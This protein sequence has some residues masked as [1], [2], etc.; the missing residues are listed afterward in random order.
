MKIKKKFTLEIIILSV[1]LAITSLIIIDNT[2]NVEENFSILNDELIP[3]LSLLKDMR[4]MA[5]N[6]LISTLEFT[7]F[8]EN[9]RVS[10]DK[11]HDTNLQSSKILSEIEEN[12][13]LFIQLFELYKHQVSG[14]IATESI[15]QINL[16]WEEFTIISDKF[17]DYRKRGISGDEF[18]KIKNEFKNSKDV[19]F[20]EIDSLLILNEKQVEQKGKDVSELVKFSTVL[21]IIV[22][23]VFIFVLIIL[24]HYLLKSILKPIFQIR[25]ATQEIAKNKLHLR[26]DDISKD[27]IG[28]LS[29]DINLMTHKLETVQDKLLKSE[30]LSVVGVLAGRMAHDIRN[31]LAIIMASLEILKLK[32][33]D[34]ED[35]KFTKINNAVNRI[36]HQ[37]EDVLD[38]V[39]TTP[40]LIEKTSIL[41]ILTNILDSQDL[42]DDV[43]V[44]LPQ[45]DV[46]ARCDSQKMRIVFLNLLLNAIDAVGK[47]GEIKIRFHD[48]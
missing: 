6:V 4:L 20:V 46:I 14:T 9:F 39:K 41:D 21:I 26:I 40:L 18:I 48:Y 47:R 36:T 34:I 23:S 29:E 5:S 44:V 24:R 27:E 3:R 17:V 2:L 31:P 16:K 33:P 19:L 37:I 15:E 42:Y 7:L 22:V 1:I 32:Y 43:D 30:K 11:V 35:A 45:N 28:E 38:F 8:E 10:G 12:K 13:I 25:S